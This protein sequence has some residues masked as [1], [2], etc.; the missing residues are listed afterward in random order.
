MLDVFM[1]IKMICESLLVEK[2]YY[3]TKIRQ[4][5]LKKVKNVCLDGSLSPHLSLEIIL[6]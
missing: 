3:N 1:E 4:N 2:C 6:L 5:D